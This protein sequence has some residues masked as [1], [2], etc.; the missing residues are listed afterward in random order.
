[1]LNFREKHK[2]DP[3]PNERS[4]QVLNDEAKAI[5]EKYELEN[6]I[7]HLVRYI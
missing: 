2:R 5:I 6:K 1:M 4:Q 3:L 7:D